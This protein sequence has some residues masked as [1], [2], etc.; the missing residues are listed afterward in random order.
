[1]DLERARRFHTLLDKLLELEPADQSDLLDRECGDDNELRRELEEALAAEAAE[2]DGIL[3]PPRPIPPP[4]PQS[5]TS[6]NRPTTAELTSTSV[7]RQL[8]ASGAAPLFVALLLLTFALVGGAARGTHQ[9]LSGVDPHFSFGSWTGALHFVDRDV[10]PG[11]RTGDVIAAV[12]SETVEGRPAVLRRAILDLEPGSKAAI[13]VRRPG[14]PERVI[15]EAHLEGFTALE[16]VVG[17]SR[18][19]IGFSLLVI[20]LIALALRPRHHAAR[21]FLA[22][23]ASL[24]GYLL[25]YLALFPFPREA[26]L[27]EKLCLF[28]TVGTSLHLYAAYPQRLAVARWIPLFYAPFAVAC[29]AG[30]LYR[31]DWAAGVGELLRLA[32]HV[33]VLGAVL[34][35]SFVGLQIRQ[36]RIRR[37]TVAL[38]QGRAL[39]VGM[40]AL[41]ASV[42][43]DVVPVLSSSIAWMFNSTVVVLFAGIVAY[44]IVR[45]NALDIDRFTA[46]LVG[47]GGTSVILAAFFAGAVIGIPALLG[48]EFDSPLVT[49][50]ITGACFLVFQPL[51][52]RLRLRVDRLFLRHERDEGVEVRLIHQLSSQVRVRELPQAFRAAIETLSILGASRIE[53]WAR[54]PGGVAFSRLS[55]SLEEPPLRPSVELD[56]A[57]AGALRSV[58]VGGVESLIDVPFE[59]PAQEELWQLGLALAAPISTEERLEGFIAVGRKENGTAFVERDRLF[60]EAVGAQLAIAMDRNWQRA[61]RIGSYVLRERLGTGG[62][63]EVFLAEKQGPGGFGR[64]VAMKRILPHLA[65]QED[66]IAMFLDE[67]RLAAR[68]HHPHIVQVYDIEQHE[69]NYYLS[70]EWL[71][72]PSLKH[73]SRAAA[74]R[75]ELMPLE[76]ALAIGEALLSALDHVHSLHD[77]RGESMGLVHRDVK[78]ANVLT[79][80][81]GDIKLGD[82]GIARAEFRL[83]QT[84]PGMSRGTPPFMAP[85]VLDGR[86]A[87]PRSDLFAAAAVLFEVLSGKTA[88]PKGPLESTRPDLPARYGAAVQRRFEVFFKHALAMDPEVRF[89]SA[90]TM[91]DAYLGAAAPT[92]PAS[93]RTT[94]ELLAR[95]VP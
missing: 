67:A 51:H 71:D 43:F 78:P 8:L 54:T 59:A 85:E 68:L 93:Q 35:V 45:H 5:S 63:A 6:T 34:S 62:M 60:L 79:S 26:L 77:D 21:L 55:A 1:M 29:L 90:R 41:A 27:F 4:V 82:F 10:W 74:E 37:E 2:I 11:L 91:L 84:G 92:G 7:R 20:A 72:G 22:L 38:A 88:F 87:T 83:Y 58:G 70:M 12:G 16:Q 3:E 61:Q 86:P 52:R 36:A 28:L 25:V 19:A 95:L 66:L 24:A 81:R 64:R 94:A 30:L 44:S 53:L 89:T 23:C 17:W 33:A 57:L 65:E 50:A 76:A 69:E 14:S 9:L 80:R 39:L 56:G 73:W 31:S 40:V 42:L 49:A 47:Y 15:A 75:P 32:P 48:R 13:E 18:L 46:A